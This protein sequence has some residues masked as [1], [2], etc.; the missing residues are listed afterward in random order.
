S[1]T[2]RG[3][4]DGHILLS[5]EL[6]ARGHYP[7]IEVLGS[8]SR[9]MRDV[10]SNEHSNSAYELQRMLATY[11][12]SEDLISVGAYKAGTNP[13]TDKAISKIDAIN[14]FLMQSTNELISFDETVDRLIKL[15]H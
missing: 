1:D 4:L 12:K 15:V 13:E 3:I 2:V 10:I 6:A 7:A 11:R 5:R 8:I 14:K 9:V